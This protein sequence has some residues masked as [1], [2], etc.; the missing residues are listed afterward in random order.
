MHRSLTHGM[1][2]PRRRFMFGYTLCDDLM[3]LWFLDRTQMLLS[4][5]IEWITVGT[6]LSPTCDAHVFR[7]NHLV[8]VRFFAALLFSQPHD[9]GWDATVTT[10]SGADGSPQYDFTVE[11]SDGTQTQYRSL[12]FI[13]S[14]PSGKGTQVW[15]VV[16]L[17]NGQPHGDPVVLKDTWR[18]GELAQEG[19]NIENIRVSA[20]G[21]GE[22]MV[23]DDH[24]PT[25][26]HHGDVV[27]HSQSGVDAPHLDST[28]THIRNFVALCKGEA[29]N[30]PS[31][32]PPGTRLGPYYGTGLKWGRTEI[33]G[34]RI[35]YRIVFGEDCIPLR[36]YKSPSVVFDALAD[37]SKGI[38]P[39]LPP[40]HSVDA[41]LQPSLSYTNMVGCIAISAT[42]IFWSIRKAAC[43]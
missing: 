17:R 18:H 41:R 8:V 6:R 19:G 33:R 22:R 12:E 39:C 35:H 42:T 5:P 2:N 4:D 27:I 24:L 31:Q 25:V 10:F 14:T 23:L 3:E 37:V 28:Q 13:A 7:Q 15:R 30:E 16:E 36:R 26:L 32:L 1:S 21:E 38:F 43:V 34:R 9:L 29:V 40:S 11:D 20:S